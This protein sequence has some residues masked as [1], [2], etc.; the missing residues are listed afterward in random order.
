MTALF[1]FAEEPFDTIGGANKFPVLLW[2]SV[3]GQTSFQI[4]LQA[5]YGG[6]IDFF[7]FRDEGY[8]FLISFGPAGLVEQRQ[9]F[10]LHQVLLFFWDVAKESRQ[11]KL[12]NFLGSD[13]SGVCKTP[14]SL[15]KLKWFTNF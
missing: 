13:L 5:R 6:R 2:K 4:A 15:N 1:D 8:H 12:T 3:E 7:I 9:K 10:R 14:L 11:N